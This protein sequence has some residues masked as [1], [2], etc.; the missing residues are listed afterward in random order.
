MVACDE[1]VVDLA[2]R[3]GGQRLAGLGALVDIQLELG[4]HGLANDR[5]ADVVELLDDQMLAQRRV[6]TRF[7]QVRVQQRLV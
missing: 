1:I 7:Q 4:E 5:G 6:V 2:E 3:I